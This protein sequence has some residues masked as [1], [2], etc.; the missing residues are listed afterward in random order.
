MKKYILYLLLLSCSCLFANHNDFYHDFVATKATNGKAGQGNSDIWRRALADWSAL[1]CNTNST[2][3]RTGERVAF[4]EAFRNTLKPWSWTARKSGV[5]KFSTVEKNPGF[6]FAEEW[7][8]SVELAATNKA[9]SIKKTATEMMSVTTTPVSNFTVYN[10]V[11]SKGW[12]LKYL[13]SESS[14][15]G[16]GNAFDGSRDTFWATKGGVQYPHEIQIDMGAEYKIDGFN[17][18]PALRIEYTDTYIKDYEFYASSDGINWTLKSTGTWDNTSTE[19]SHLFP[20]VIARYIRLKA[21]SGY[22]RHYQISVAEL[23]VKLANDTLNQVEVLG[24]T[25]VLFKDTSS[26]APTSW[27]WTISQN[28][29]V[30]FTSTE[31]NPRF[32]FTE[33]GFYDVE[34]TT[35]NAAGS[36]T[37]TVSSLIHVTA[38]PKADFTASQDVIKTGERVIFTDSSTN[39][40]D[41]WSWT[42]SLEGVEKFTSKEQDPVFTFTEPGIYS[43]ELTVTNKAGSNTKTLQNLITVGFPIANFTASSTAIKTG[44]S[45]SFTD[46]SKNEPTSWSWK[47]TKQGEEKF[48]SVEQNLVFTFTEEGVYTVELTASNESGSNTKTAAGMI[49][50]ATP[51]VSGFTVY[52]NVSIKGWT[53]KYASSEH[54]SDKAINAFDGDR[55]TT[56]SSDRSF[57]A[58]T[59]PC[60]IQIDM[61]GQYKIDGFNY[62]LA[63][64]FAGVPHGKIKDYEFYISTDGTNWDLMDSGSWDDTNEDKIQLFT[65]FTARYIRLRALSGYARYIAIAELGA[66]LANDDVIQVIA[67][68]PVSFIDTS[69]NNPVSWSWKVSQ[70]GV[71]KLASTAQNP[72][73]AFTDGGLYDVELTTSNAGG[74]DTKTS[75]GLI[76]VVVMPKADFTAS[77]TAINLGQSITFTDSSTGIPESW[78]WRVNKDGEE[79]F[80]SS[81]QNPV[82]TFTQPGAYSV[83]LTVKN[84][85]GSDTKTVNDMIKVGIPQADFTASVTMINPGDSITFTDTSLNSPLS[86]EWSITKNG[87]LVF[88]SMEQH[89]SFTF[90]EPGRY[91]VSLTA[92]ND[93]GSDTKAVGGLIKVGVPKAN[94]TA[95]ATMIN[96]GERIAFSDTSTNEPALWG[97]SITKNEI[98]LFSSIE[99][100]PSFTFTEAGRY[101][102]MLTASNTVGQD[103]KTVA[104]MIQ[105]NLR[106]TAPSNIVV[107]SPVGI[108]PYIS[109]DAKEGAG[110]YEYVLDTTAEAPAAAGT[111]LTGNFYQA[112]SLTPSTAYFF[113]LRSK[114]G[115]MRSDWSTVSFTTPLVLASD[116]FTIITRSES[117]AGENNGR[118]E[119]T[120]KTA[121]E[122]VALINGNSYNFTG[123]SLR[124]DALA[125]GTYNVLISIAG[126]AFQQAFNLTIDK[127]VAISAQSRM[128][129]DKIEV[130][131]QKGSA[132]YSVLLNEVE[133]F[134]TDDRGFSVVVKNGDVLKVKTARSCEGEFEKEIQGLR[135]NISAYPNPTE[136]SFEI[137]LPAS[138]KQVPISIYDATGN[139]ISNQVYTVEDSK[140][141]LTLE[142]QPMGIYLVRVGWKNT[143]D[144]KIIKK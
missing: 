39:T 32:V 124:V 95:S 60:E 51:P 100:N 87:M 106:C 43:V 82:L 113:H 56:W 53:L 33:E 122:Y 34:L 62:A 35:A 47:I 123:N 125:P 37:K 104:D 83:E 132:P 67:G 120:A 48:T 121:F 9:C 91:S 44:N 99:Q 107:S 77:K 20:A 75:A 118:I 2:L 26:N 84:L 46:I 110:G 119:I 65:A 63:W 19:K 94:F 18:I 143:V 130:Q 85:A 7:N 111:L 8:N 108:S 52:N 1:D 31:Q 5:Q 42:V 134:K 70:N 61:G 133:Q 17:C 93:G 71:V 92:R 21:L 142:G 64:H 144:I 98:L 129:N 117:C 136:G 76:R 128:D 96:T 14:I 140:V 90:A 27:S 54:G 80:T 105:V 41:S 73:F 58:V 16:G 103:T 126:E 29:A 127:A 78:H 30:K 135:E 141:R 69:L 24:G 3:M 86:W 13:S 23:G 12:S 137:A 72:S 36:D 11:P 10:N 25:S 138:L 97:W 79:K 74:S 88:S 116:N 139:L 50:V 68:S 15:F 66:K 89:P 102:V 45:I 112:R 131:M 109:W 55:N 28:D 40:P 22:G 49:T 101:T 4:N 38:I 114:C 59:Y 6:A 81:D 115:E 57:E